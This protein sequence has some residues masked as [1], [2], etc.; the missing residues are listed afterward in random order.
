M[1]YMAL[2]CSVSVSVGT[3]RARFAL[4]VANGGVDPVELTFRDAGRAD[5]AVIE[6][7]T[8]RWRWS[9]GRMFAQAQE[10]VELAPG[11]TFDIQA[12]WSD[13]KSGTYEL[14]GELRAEPACDARTTFSV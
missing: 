11:E 3:G 8:E 2:D 6:D 12:E 1:V 7:G 13:P 4:S 5:F 10:T 14:L 9:D